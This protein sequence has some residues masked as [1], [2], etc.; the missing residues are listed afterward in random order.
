MFISQGQWENIIILQGQWEQIYYL[1]DI[2]DLSDIYL[3]FVI[4]IRIVHSHCLLDSSH[5][6]F[7]A[8]I[9]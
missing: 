3:S 9:L 5:K 8:C 4:G 1:L 2:K 6:T 7:I